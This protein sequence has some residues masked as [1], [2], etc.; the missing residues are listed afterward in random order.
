MQKIKFTK[1]QI[2]RFSSLQPLN[3]TKMKRFKIP[4]CFFTKNVHN[5]K[6][7]NPKIKDEHLKM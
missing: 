2:K 3:I 4:V 1:Q 7:H 6:K 5:L